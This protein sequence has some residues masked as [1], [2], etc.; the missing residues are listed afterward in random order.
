MTDYKQIIEDVVLIFKILFLS[1]YYNAEAFFRQFVPA[2]YLN[3]DVQGQI[4][5]VTGGGKLLLA[6]HLVNSG[7]LLTWPMFLKPTASAN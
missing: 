5:L 7:V 6:G 2:K 3:K 1:F 4:V